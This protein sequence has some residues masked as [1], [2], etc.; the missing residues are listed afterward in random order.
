[1]SDTGIGSN[2]ILCTGKEIEAQKETGFAQDHIASIWQNNMPLNSD[3]KR[4]LAQVSG[5]GPMSSKPLPRGWLLIYHK[6]PN[7]H[8]SVFN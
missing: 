2:I 6:H 8:H 4:N 5:P 1:M 3:Y 7:P